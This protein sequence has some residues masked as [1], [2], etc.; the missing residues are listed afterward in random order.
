MKNLVLGLLIFGLTIQGFS[1][2]EEVELQEKPVELQEVEVKGINSQYL[3]SV[4]DTETATLVRALEEKAANFDLLSSQYFEEVYDDY[5]IN[6]KALYGL[7]MAQ[8][9]NKGEI[10]QTKERF[11]DIGLPLKVSNAVVDNYPGWKITGDIYIVEYSRAKEKAFKMY[12]LS[13]EKDG[14]TEKIK[15]D[16]HGNII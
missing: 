6:F 4:G 3:N 8:Y 16:G 13:I 2:V 14:K 10:M 5:F 15:T 7:I 12:K 9:D 11:V 1:Q